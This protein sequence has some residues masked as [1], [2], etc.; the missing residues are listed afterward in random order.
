MIILATRHAFHRER[1]PQ[2]HGDIDG[3]S[4]A[5]GGVLVLRLR[6]SA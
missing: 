1:H 3:A 2:R 6:T 4:V 5:R